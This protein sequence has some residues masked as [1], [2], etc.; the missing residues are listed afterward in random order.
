MLARATLLTYGGI[1]LQ[2]VLIILIYFFLWKV[3]K[4]AWRDLHDVSLQQRQPE[5]SKYA[6]ARLIVIS[7]S[8]LADQEFL[9]E[10]SLSIGRHD[11]NDIVIDDAF[12]SFE[13]AC[14]TSAKQ[15]YILTDLGSTNGTFLNDRRIKEDE[16]LMSGDRVTIGPVTFRFER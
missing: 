13:H 4:L 6:A 9:L 5:P 2:Y 11:T 1:I 14:L 15:G 8:L 7:T 12:V 10:E 16:L 3:L